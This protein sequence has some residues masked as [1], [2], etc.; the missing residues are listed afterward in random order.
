MDGIATINWRMDESNRYGNYQVIADGYF[1]AADRLID[2]LLRNNVGNDADA[3]I[4]PIMFCGYHGIELYLKATIGINRSKQNNQ[5]N[6]NIEG[7]HDVGTLIGYLNSELPPSEQ[8]NDSN[9]DAETKELFELLGFFN[10]IGI[11]S[12][13]QFHVDF[14]RYPESKTK[15]GSKLYSFVTSN[16]P[17]NIDLSILQMHL[18]TIRELFFGLYSRAEAGLE[19]TE[20]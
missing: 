11:D 15:Q 12:G 9:P 5:W 1:I 18:R 14:A 3:V 7:G 6:V 8:L 13:G 16:D 2:S 4:F 19:C 20:Y 17:I 10:S